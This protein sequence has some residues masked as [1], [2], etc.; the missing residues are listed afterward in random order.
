MLCVTENVFRVE[1]KNERVVFYTVCSMV[2]MYMYLT[3]LDLFAIAITKSEFILLVATL[4]LLSLTLRCS[5]SYSTTH[6]FI[7]VSTFTSVI[8]KRKRAFW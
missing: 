2:P 1:E 3:G 4:L 8:L 5:R 7:I 6:G